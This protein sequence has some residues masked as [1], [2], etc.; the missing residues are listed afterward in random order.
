MMFSDLCPFLKKNNPNINISFHGNQVG[1]IVAIVQLKSFPLAFQME[2][3][4]VHWI[5]HKKLVEDELWIF[6]F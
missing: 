4:Y 1:D 2:F 3:K 6:H 5:L